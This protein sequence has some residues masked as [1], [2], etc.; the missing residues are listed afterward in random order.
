MT[1]IMNPNFRHRYLLAAAE[2]LPL[3]IDSNTKACKY[4]LFHVLTLCLHKVKNKF[5]I[6]GYL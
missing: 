1:F 6:F 4:F 2:E 5:S 3:Y